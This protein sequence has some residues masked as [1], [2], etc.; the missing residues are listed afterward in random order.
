MARILNGGHG[1]PDVHQ[2]VLASEAGS[3]EPLRVYDEQRDVPAC[4]VYVLLWYAGDDCVAGDARGHCA[5][6]V[7]RALGAEHARSFAPR[8]EPPPALQLH[9]R[10]EADDADNDVVLSILVRAGLG[11]VLG[12]DDFVEGSVALLHFGLL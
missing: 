3:Y 8:G 4:D 5:R 11:R 1:A 6:R 9:V 12:D 2:V 7:E 10:D